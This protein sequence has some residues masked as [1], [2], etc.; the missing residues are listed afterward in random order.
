MKTY[1]KGLV[2]DEAFVRAAYADWCRAGAGRKNRWRIAE[3]H[4]SADALVAE[5]V[6]EVEARSLSLRPIR[7]YRLRDGSSGKV[8]TIGVES[9]KQQVLDY[10]A[11]RAL[12]P[13]M[14]AKVGWYQA[15]SVKG[16]GQLFAAR[17]VR[18]WVQEGGYWV[19]MDIRQ[20]YPSISH[21]VAMRTVSRNVRN[22][23][24]LY[25]V[26]SLLATYGQGLEIGSYFSLRLAQ[27][28]LSYGYHHVEGLGKA[29]RGRRRPLVAHQIWYMDDV[30]LFAPDKRDLRCAARSLERYM[31]S[32]LGLRMKPWKVCRVSDDEPVDVAG[33]VVRAGRTTVRAGLFLR[34]RASF[35]RYARAPTVRLARR[36]CS[37][38]GWL[39]N[40]DS[41]GFVAR[42]GADGIRR[43]AGRRIS[44]SARREDIR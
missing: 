28:A 37:Y 24:V 16:K 5:I 25:V 22:P 2:I 11:V 40:S 9:V 31:R 10:V 41:A 34:A 4:G 23:D 30:Y 6:R 21:E 13:L 17:A 15:S 39:S 36:V 35:R 29:R 32:E 18:R 19:H 3:E 43:R 1:C 14:A 44:A 26:R 12:E 33:Y 42:S 27:L 7:R 20:C 8:R 38:W